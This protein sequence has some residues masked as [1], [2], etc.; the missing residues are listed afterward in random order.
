MD[1]LLP[2]IL[3]LLWDFV[4]H[5]A[6]LA[7]YNFIFNLFHTFPLFPSFLILVPISL[8]MQAVRFFHLSKSPSILGI[9][10]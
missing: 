8:L 7:L 9:Q 6:R 3:D 2:I 5:I 1:T 4:S 10:Y